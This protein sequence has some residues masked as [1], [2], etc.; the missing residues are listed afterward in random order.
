MIKY[1]EHVAEAIE[2]LGQYLG[3]VRSAR[4]AGWGEEC[5]RD[6]QEQTRKAMIAATP[7]PVCESLGHQHGHGTHE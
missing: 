6:L 2:A 1:R 7:C 5:L 3:C 4:I